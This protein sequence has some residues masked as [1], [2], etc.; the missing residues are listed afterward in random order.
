M[1]DHKGMRF[2]MANKDAKGKAVVIYSCAPTPALAM[3]ELM[4]LK[5]KAL[6]KYPKRRIVGFADIDPTL[7]IGDWLKHYTGKDKERPLEIVAEIH[8]LEKVGSSN[9][10]QE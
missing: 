3:A 9:G 8:E 6:E 2:I 4:I 7:E 10:N 1:I 5:D